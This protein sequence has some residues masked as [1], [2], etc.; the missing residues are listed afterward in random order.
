MNSIHWKNI[1]ETIGTVSIIA[2]LVFVGLEIR[3]NTNA[4]RSS[5]IQDIARWSYDATILLVENTDLLNASYAECVSDLSDEQYNR[6]Q[7]WYAALL[8]VQLNR[9][10]QIQLGIIDEQMAASIGG[11]GAAYRNPFFAQIWPALKIDFDQG[12]Q[13]YIENEVLPLSQDSC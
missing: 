7:A 11:R 1:V 13:D 5:A 4:V 8:R 6:M 3:Q 10:Y 9:Y 2:T 12:F